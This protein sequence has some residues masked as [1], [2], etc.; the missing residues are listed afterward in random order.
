MLGIFV[1]GGLC[2]AVDNLNPAK[3]C[4]NGT[5][6]IFHSLSFEGATPE[7]V[8]AAERRGGFCEVLLEEPPLSVNF[9]LSVDSSARAAWPAGETCIPD[10]EIQLS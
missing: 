1:E 10:A 4:A 3:Q 8:L 2:Q 9:E 5:R 7:A 6:A